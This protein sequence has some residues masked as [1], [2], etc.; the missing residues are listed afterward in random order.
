MLMGKKK[1]T[2]KHYLIYVLSKHGCSFPASLNRI[3]SWRKFT[4]FCPSQQLHKVEE[5]FQHK[6]IRDPVSPGRQRWV[7]MESLWK[8]RFSKLGIQ[9]ALVSRVDAEI[10]QNINLWLNRWGLISPKLRSKG[11]ACKRWTRCRPA[12]LKAWALAQ[13]THTYN[14]AFIFSVSPWDFTLILLSFDNSSWTYQSLSAR[15]IRNGQINAQDIA[16]YQ[17]VQG[18]KL[19]CDPPPVACSDWAPAA[20]RNTSNVARRRDWMELFEPRASTYAPWGL[21]THRRFLYRVWG[22]SHHPFPISKGMEYVS[23]EILNSTISAASCYS[24]EVIL[25]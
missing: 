15:I 9:I 16:Y 19:H 13:R 18:V 12:I 17:W 1:S 7:E 20:G 4:S 3:W 5:S 11:S 6:P 10:F 8:V 24:W 14:I 22:C 25:Y 21:H 2:I 23:G